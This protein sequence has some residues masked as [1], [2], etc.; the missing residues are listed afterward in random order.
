MVKYTKQPLKH[1]EPKPRKTTP[2]ETARKA[3]QKK[4]K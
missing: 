2:F 1:P 4:S 3:A